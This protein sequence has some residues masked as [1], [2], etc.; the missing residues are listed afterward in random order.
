MQGTPKA[1]GRGSRARLRQIDPAKTT[2]V[3]H[4]AFGQ[5]VLQRVNGDKWTVEFKKHGKKVIL[6]D[7]LRVLD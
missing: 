2:R 6:S 7:Y 4:S 3:F 5:G 1:R